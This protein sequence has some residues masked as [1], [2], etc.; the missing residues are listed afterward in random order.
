MDVKKVNALLCALESGSMLKAA[1]ELG[2]TPSALTHMMDALERELEIKITKR[3]RFGIRLTPEGEALLPLLQEYSNCEKRIRQEIRSINNR[4]QNILRIGVYDSLARNWLPQM[5][6]RFQEQNGPVSVEMF[7]A[8]PYSLFEALDKSMLDVLFTGEIETYPH[9]FTSIIRDHFHAVLPPGYDNG[10]RDCFPIEEFEGMPFL[11]P[12][13]GTDFHVLG[14]L[15]KHNIKPNFLPTKADDP[16]VI[17]MVANGMGL[18]M[19]SEMVLMGQE[20]DIQTPLIVP[21]EYRVLGIATKE[22]STLPKVTSR[23][24]EF[25]LENSEYERC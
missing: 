14:A 16:V 23:F 8:N 3:G 18:S 9:N 11:I 24:I 1:E 21:E 17:G 6:N 15:E 5:I 12:S 2:Y 13:Y 4:D 7:A 19:L 20:Y 25:V 22:N 10:G